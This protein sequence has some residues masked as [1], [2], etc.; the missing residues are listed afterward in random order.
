MIGSD[1]PVF[2]VEVDRRHRFQQIHI[3]LM[4]YRLLA[5]FSRTSEFHRLDR[6]AWRYLDDLKVPDLKAVFQYWDAQTD[7]AALT[8]FVEQTPEINLLP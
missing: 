1:E 5:R 3:G 2:L 4:L 8:R 7:D 6:R